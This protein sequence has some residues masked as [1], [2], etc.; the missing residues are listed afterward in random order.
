[1]HLSKHKSGMFRLWR[2]G[3]NNI[4]TIITRRNLNRYD[5]GKENFKKIYVMRYEGWASQKKVMH[6]P[7]P[8]GTACV[9]FICWG[10]N[11][12][13]IREKL[14]MFVYGH[15]EIPNKIWTC[16]EVTNT[17]STYILA[18]PSI[19]IS[20]LSLLPLDYQ[21]LISLPFSPR[22]G[23]SPPHSFLVSDFKIYFLTYHLLATRNRRN[24]LSQS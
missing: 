8:S 9:L 4:P 10:S 15:K 7:C 6:F 1:M 19:L 22:E 5:N 2:A 20:I 11:S 18:F 24:G 13:L 12:S 16:N 17:P 14:H 3:A 23:V 21:T